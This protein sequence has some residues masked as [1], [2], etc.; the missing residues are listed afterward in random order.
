MAAGE[1]R[2]RELANRIVTAAGFDLEDFAVVNAGRRRLIRVIIDADHGVGLDAMAAVSRDLS[3]AFDADD[4]SA[5]AADS[6]PY[7]LEVSSPGIGRPLSEPRHFHRARGRLVAITTTAGEALTA[8]VLGITD[9]GV[10]LLDG[11]AGTELRQLPFGEIA[12]AKVE[13][14]FSGPTKAVAALLAAD[15]RSAD[16]AAAE[17]HDIADDDA[18]TPTDTHE[19]RP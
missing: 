11:K 1:Q 18:E 16:M 15:P 9:T 14:D 8:R 5:G 19:E 4:E 17:Q 2:W 12:R 13:V 3:A 6:T 10:D 7:T